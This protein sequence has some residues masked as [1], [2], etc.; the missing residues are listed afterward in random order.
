MRVRILTSYIK[1]RLT[2]LLTLLHKIY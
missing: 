2:Y 1:P